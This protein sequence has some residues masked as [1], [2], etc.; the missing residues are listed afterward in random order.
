MPGR[1]RGNL[2]SLKDSAVP[3]GRQVVRRVLAAEVSAIVERARRQ[4]PVDTGRSRRELAIEPMP[5]RGR[6]QLR[7]RIRATYY[8]PFILSRGL[9]PWRDLI[10]RPIAAL[11]RNIP[12]VLARAMVR[13]AGGRR[14][15]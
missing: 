13:E 6:G 5:D 9:R 12:G 11:I 4:W 14:G 2:L 15:R 3:A 1:L 7:M 8:S 10:Q